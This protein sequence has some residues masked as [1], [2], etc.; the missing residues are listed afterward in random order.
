MKKE[1]N[2]NFKY[3]VVHQERDENKW[4][5]ALMFYKME[6]DKKDKE[7]R[8]T[9]VYY[10]EH[11]TQFSTYDE[12]EHY[13]FALNFNSSRN[14]YDTTRYFPIQIDMTYLPKLITHEDHIEETENTTNNDPVSEPSDDGNGET[15]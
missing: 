7:V 1:L 13:A 6:Y 10:P 9:S 3:F 4:G 11:A 5:M 8:W 15:A 12:A 14:N 2:N